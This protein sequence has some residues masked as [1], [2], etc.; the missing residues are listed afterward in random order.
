MW[1]MA[2]ILSLRDDAASLCYVEELIVLLCYC[3]VMFYGG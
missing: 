1:V 3:F 2:D